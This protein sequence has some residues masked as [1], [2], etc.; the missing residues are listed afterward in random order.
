MRSW[1][2]IGTER[3]W[4]C[5]LTIINIWTKGSKRYS[6][7]MECSPLWKGRHAQLRERLAAKPCSSTYQSLKHTSFDEMPR[8]A[9]HKSTMRHCATGAA[10]P[11]ITELVALKRVCYAAFCRSSDAIQL[12]LGLRRDLSCAN[13][14]S[15]RHQTGAAQSDTLQQ[16]G[17]EQSLPAY[18]IRSALAV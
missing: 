2:D 14:P 18:T 17:R 10:K 13:V 11:S 9:V 7:R 1:R 5:V 6:V 15:R 4:S 12:A 8:V 16:A 3:I